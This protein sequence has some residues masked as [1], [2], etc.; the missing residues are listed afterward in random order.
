MRL[1][2]IVVEVVLFIAALLGGFTLGVIYDRTVLSESCVHQEVRVL[3]NSLMVC[4]SWAEAKRW[5]PPVTYGL[6]K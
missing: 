6:T 2:S 5:E 3:G 1:L 4:R